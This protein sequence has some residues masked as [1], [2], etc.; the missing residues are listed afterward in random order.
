ML[1]EDGFVMDDG[2]TS[3]LGPEHFLMTTTTANAVE[4]DAASGVLPSVPVAGPRRADG[5]G[6]RSNG[7]SS[8]IAGPRSR[9]VLARVVDRQHDISNAAFPYLTAR[10]VT[11]LGGTPARLF[12]ISFSGELAY[13]LAVPAGVGGS[14]AERS[15]P[16]AR[17]LASRPTGSRRW[18]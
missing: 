18:A 5:D 15:W 6:D 1:R 13:E 8:A 14:V 3:R 17:I 2:T 11:V 7:R 12:R 9:D 4:R 10:A 16:P